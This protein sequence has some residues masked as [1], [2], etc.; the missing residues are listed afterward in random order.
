MTERK[1]NPKEQVAVDAYKTFATS[2]GM[3]ILKDLENYCN[4]SKTTVKPDGID[5]NELIFKEGK[6]SVFLHIKK[7]LAKSGINIFDLLK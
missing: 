1:F 7:K 4:F 2:E 5:Q 6:R 3:V